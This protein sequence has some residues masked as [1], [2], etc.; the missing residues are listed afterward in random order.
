MVSRNSDDESRYDGLRRA[1]A[2]LGLIRR[3]SLVRRFM[4]CGKS[5]CRCQAEPPELHGPYY[6]WT[7]KVR[8]KTVTVRLTGEEAKAFEE[9]I[10]NGRQLDKIVAQMESV[11]LRITER[12]LRQARR[13]S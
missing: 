3:G 4:P 2:D 11:S 7:R 12:L 9:W 13:E 10:A 5:G 6:Q 1:V 8:G